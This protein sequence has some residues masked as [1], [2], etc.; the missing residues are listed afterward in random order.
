MNHGIYDREVHVRRDPEG[1]PKLCELG[2]RAQLKK[3][4]KINPT[5]AENAAHKALLD[6]SIQPWRNVL[7]S[8]PM[9]Y[10]NNIFMSSY[11]LLHTI[12]GGIMKTLMFSACVII[13][14][15]SSSNDKKFRDA[16][17]VFDSRLRTYPDV[18]DCLPHV[19]KTTFRKGFMG[20]LLGKSSSQ[21]GLATN[22][23]GRLRSSHFVTLLLQAYFAIGR[24]RDVLPNDANYR[25]Q[26]GRARAGGED[27]DGEPAN[28]RA[29]KIM[30]LRLGNVSKKVLDAFEFV[31]SVYFQSR[32]AAHTDQSMAEL[33][34]SNERS[35]DISLGIKAGPYW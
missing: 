15:I 35:F 29:K 23:C 14:R 19:P 17:G 26:K 33:R 28:K 20:V 9:G 13:D 1:I 4:N 27:N 31:L 30:D 18:P 5:K 32:R 11:D 21:Q 12:P 10:E 8:A 24:K 2:E 34:E 25:Y 3:F 7:H 6:M 16:R 22:S